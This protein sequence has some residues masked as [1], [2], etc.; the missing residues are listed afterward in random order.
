[1]TIETATWLGLYP[2]R[3]AAARTR[4]LVGALTGRLAENV[5]L[6]VAGETL[7]IRATSRIV[8]TLASLTQNVLL[9]KS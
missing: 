2:A 9:I 7:A 8:A 6:T 1:V 3:A 5:W 4:A